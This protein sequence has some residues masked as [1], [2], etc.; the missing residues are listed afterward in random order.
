[1]R[2][3]Q[4]TRHAGAGR[5]GLTVLLSLIFLHAEAHPPATIPERVDLQQAMAAAARRPAQQAADARVG[6]AQLLADGARRQAWW[7][8][9]SLTAAARHLSDI[10]TADTPVG[11]LSFGEHDVV[12]SQL[13]FSQPLL[14]WSRMR[15]STTAGRLGAESAAL[16]AA[17][18]ADEYR[19]AA[20]EAYFAVLSIEAQK[21]ALEQMQRSMAARIVRE[22]AWLD[23]GRILRADL[24]RTQLLRDGVSQ[25][26]AALGE[27]L[28][29]AQ[30]EL[31]LAIGTPGPATA[32]EPRIQAP[33]ALPVLES[34]IAGALGSRHDL[35]ALQR[36]IEAV[37]MQARAVVAEALPTVD[38]L[39]QY[40][41]RSGAALQPDHEAAIGLRLDWKLFDS[42]TRRLRADALREQQ[43]ALQFELEER[44][45]LVRSQLSRAYA[46]FTKARQI[47]V[48]AQSGLSSATQTLQTRD[49]LY[50]Q[51]RSNIDE[52]LS[53]EA[54]LAQQRALNQVAGYDAMRSWVAFHVAAGS[55][56]PVLE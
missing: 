31:G 38:L 6:A 42:G 16:Q 19:L 50:A 14:N 23:D 32:A 45:Q 13:T 41:E 39:A 33:Q 5:L 43:R 15:Y 11:E 24:L 1:M 26:L 18:S 22:Q 30:V 9:L 10:P 17:R 29:I 46:G 21:A 40:A 37:D 12:T 3:L 47:Q 20:A 28:D 7:P 44:R 51:G 8:S 36:D 56:L 4:R 49:A 48:L 55:P 25:Q 54:E 34:A 52:V 53:A 2:S 27:D 35:L